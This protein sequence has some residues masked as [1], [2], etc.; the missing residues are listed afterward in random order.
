MVCI[1]SSYIPSTS[2][3]FTPTRW[4]TPVSDIVLEKK[5]K[6]YC[7]TKQIQIADQSVNGYNISMSS[8]TINSKT[9]D[10]YF[11]YLKKLDNRSKKELIVRLMESLD[12]NREKP[13]EVSS[14]F[15][16]W[17]DER[18]SDEIIRELIEERVESKDP[19]KFE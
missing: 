5:T 9:I 13:G 16:A 11:N 1:R 3:S 8:L 18:S 14:L 2:S 12:I 7:Y 19:E 6:I 10:K 17:K 4:L 15:G